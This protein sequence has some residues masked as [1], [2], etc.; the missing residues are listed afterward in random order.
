M[1]VDAINAFLCPKTGISPK[2]IGGRYTDA[3]F[4]APKSYNQICLTNDTALSR[5]E[6]SHTHAEKYA[7]YAGQ[8]TVKLLHP[9]GGTLS[10]LLLQISVH[11]STLRFPAVCSQYRSFIQF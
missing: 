5:K 11:T 9:A 7:G 1:H 3:F 8:Q 10:L 4:I 2:Y 6:D